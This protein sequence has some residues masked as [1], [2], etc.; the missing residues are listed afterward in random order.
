MSDEWCGA[1]RIARPSTRRSSLATQRF[2][3]AGAALICLP[4]LA[5]CAGHRPPPPPAPLAAVVL[6][7]IADPPDRSAVQGVF[8]FYSW[9]AATRA[10]VPDQLD[11]ALRQTLAA[12]GIAVAAPRGESAIPAATL[13][14]AT[15]AVIASGLD[16]PALFVALD[17]WEA[18]NTDFPAF[19]NV[20]LSASLIA[21]DGRLLWT[22]RRDARP[23]ATRGA[24][25]LAA[26]YA[27]AA[28]EVAT[29]LVGS[30]QPASAAP[31]P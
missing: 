16:A 3:V 30:W 23:V 14:A 28:G 8:A 1:T 7:P 22:T 5:A 21:P 4:L 26:A 27:R 9:I 10:A 15:E 29:W 12:R 18:E 25:G 31:P 13:R 2:G 17:K 6:L 19:V 11:A 24:S 20:A